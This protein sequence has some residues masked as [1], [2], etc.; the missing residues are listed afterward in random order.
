MGLLREDGVY[1][2]FEDAVRKPKEIRLS[3]FNGFVTVTNPVSREIYP[4][5]NKI[6]QLSED[7]RVIGWGYH[8][9]EFDLATRELWSI[10]TWIEKT[11]VHRRRGEMGEVDELSAS[12]LRVL[13]AEGRIDYVAVGQH[14][15]VLPA[16]AV[17]DDATQNFVFD[18]EDD[19]NGGE[20]QG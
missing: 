2:E 14:A 6:G 9:V 19:G 10:W 20:H 1:M 7:D 5:R 12:Q 17:F 13:E 15:S 18:G 16:N 3:R 11:L 8:W 4:F